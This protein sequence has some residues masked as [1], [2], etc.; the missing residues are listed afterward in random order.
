MSK[1][2]NSCLITNTD[3][4]FTLPDFLITVVGKTDLLKMIAWFIFAAL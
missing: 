1:I 3:Q 2:F 4:H